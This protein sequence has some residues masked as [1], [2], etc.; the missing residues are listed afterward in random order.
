MHKNKNQRILQPLL[1]RFQALGQ[2]SFDNGKRDHK[3]D[4]LLA[5]FLR[6]KLSPGEKKINERIHYGVRTRMFIYRS[7]NGKDKVVLRALIV[8]GLPGKSKF[9][10][11][12]RFN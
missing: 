5:E 9:T 1:D 11:T 7:Q 12:V 2:E 8:Q 6:A 10:I 4:D 3:L